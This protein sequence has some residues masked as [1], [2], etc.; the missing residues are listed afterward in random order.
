MGCANLRKTGV[1]HGGMCA[2]F[3]P[4]E[5]T[6]KEAERLTN[7]EGQFSLFLAALL[8]I[9]GGGEQN[10]ERT[11]SPAALELPLSLSR[12]GDVYRSGPRS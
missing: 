10:R 6:G 7:T 8:V 3:Q 5:G 1:R 2:G 4:S 9:P 12:F 11:H